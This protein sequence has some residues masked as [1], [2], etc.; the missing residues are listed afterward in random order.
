MTAARV[1]D[2]CSDRAHHACSGVW[3]KCAFCSRPRHLQDRALARS[4]HKRMKRRARR[5]ALV[6]KGALLP[7]EAS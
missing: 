1:C 6:A 2:S 3:C 7:V 5:L 4:G